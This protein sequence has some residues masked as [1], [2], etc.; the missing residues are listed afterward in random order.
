MTFNLRD[1]RDRQTQ[2]KSI[3]DAFPIMLTYYDFG[4]MLKRI[5]PLNKTIGCK[6]L[7]LDV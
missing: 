6:D 7:G 3:R 2:S 5:A 4:S 1:E